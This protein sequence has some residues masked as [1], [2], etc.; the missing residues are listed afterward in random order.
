MI[1]S[2]FMRILY[3]SGWKI[4]LFLFVF[5]CLTLIAGV[6]MY[7][8]EGDSGGFSSISQ[9][10]YWAITTL[11]TTGY[12]DMIPQTDLG[13]AVHSI[14]SYLGLSLIFVPFVIV[15]AE[16]YNSLCKAFLPQNTGE[17]NQESDK[18]MKTAIVSLVALSLLVISGFSSFLGGDISSPRT[19]TLILSTLS[20]VGIWIIIMLKI[21][22]LKREKTKS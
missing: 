3:E 13:K 9:S 6:L 4:A 2:P 21:R 10:L 1:Q 17:T 14:I 16:I 20:L 22:R 11:T 5:L 19:V 8:I 15:I 12:G 18:E 7:F